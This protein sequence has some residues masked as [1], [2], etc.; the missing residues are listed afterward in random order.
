M[1]NRYSPLSSTTIFHHP[2]SSTTVHNHPSSS[3][4]IEHYA[5]SSITHNHPTS[6]NIIHLPPPSFSIIRHHPMSSIIIHECPHAHRD[7]CI[8]F[9]CLQI[10]LQYQG[11]E[12]I[13][14]ALERQ[15]IK[16]LLERMLDVPWAGN[17]D[18]TGPCRHC[19][20]SAMWFQLAH[21]LMDRVLQ[22]SASQTLPKLGKVLQ[23][24]LETR[25]FYTTEAR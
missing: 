12:R 23:A 24:S 5:P 8:H 10:K 1:Q 17:H 16:L 9:P 19:Q 21:S 3:T 22:N 11:E 25:P 6:S 13:S 20:M 2:Q 7:Y 18:H 15:G 4:I 14:N